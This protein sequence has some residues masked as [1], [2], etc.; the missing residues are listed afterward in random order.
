[1]NAEQA[2]E[3]ELSVMHATLSSY[4]NASA[5]LKTLVDWHVAVALD[6]AVNGNKTLLP[7]KLTAEN[8]AKAALMG[9]FFETVEVDCPLCEG[10]E[11][12]NDYEVCVECNDTA[13][14]TD[15]VAISWT[16]IKAIYAAAVAYFTKEDKG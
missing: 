16:N 6:P 3:N 5:A 8:G 1:M 9:E 14:I 4:E 13:T 11:F 7:K 12:K 2:L 15:E 10:G